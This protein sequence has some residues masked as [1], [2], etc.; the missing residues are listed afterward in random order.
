MALTTLALLCLTGA[1]VLMVLDLQQVSYAALGAAALLA[2]AAVVATLRERRE[3][4]VG[5]VMSGS[6]PARP[7]SAKP[8]NGRPLLRKPPPQLL[9]WP[10]RLATGPGSAEKRDQP[11][12]DAPP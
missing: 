8:R 5:I 4:D 9:E 10:T 2:A 12:I 11:E 3:H 6:A 1:F 7:A